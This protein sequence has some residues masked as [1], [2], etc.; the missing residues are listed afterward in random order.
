MTTSLLTKL[1]RRM[2]LHSTL[3]RRARNLRFKS[4]ERSGISSSD[5]KFH[6]EPGTSIKDTI[7]TE[8]WKDVI[9]TACICGCKIF[10][11]NI[12]WDEEYK[13]VGWYDLRQSCHECGR[14]FKAPTPIDEGM[15]C[16]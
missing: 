11:L 13:T 10:Q 6:V 15:D 9:A 8:E 14:V 3:E 7:G 16:E 5:I 12:M 2:D 4:L 1:L